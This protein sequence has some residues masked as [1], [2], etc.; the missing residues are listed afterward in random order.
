MVLAKKYNLMSEQA[1][2]DG[3]L[4]SE[5]SCINYFMQKD[6]IQR[7]LQVLKNTLKITKKYTKSS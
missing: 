2:L 6:I 1:Y 3:E 5:Q 4:L 7:E